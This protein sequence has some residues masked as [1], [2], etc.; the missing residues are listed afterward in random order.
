MVG[1]RWGRGGGGTP[2]ICGGVC[3]RDSVMSTIFE[4]DS[5]FLCGR[6][7][8]THPRLYNLFI[9]RTEKNPDYFSDAELQ[10]AYMGK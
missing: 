4:M 6:I 5:G 1:V 2:P 10:K 7:V 8:L 9:K 3:A